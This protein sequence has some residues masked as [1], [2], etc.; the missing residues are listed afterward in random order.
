MS[1]SFSSPFK[2]LG[3]GQTQAPGGSSVPDLKVTRLLRSYGIREISPRRIPPRERIELAWGGFELP[4]IRATG[5]NHRCVS[6]GQGATC[7][8]GTRVAGAV[9]RPTLARTLNMSG[10]SNT[11]RSRI[12]HPKVQWLP[13]PL[14]GTVSQ[15]PGK[16][17]CWGLEFRPSKGQLQPSHPWRPNPVRRC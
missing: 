14:T 16:H 3:F 17:G 7:R 12:A 8:T 15:E 10:E 4:S 5:L 1:V 9:S 2:V 13:A 6:T 11:F